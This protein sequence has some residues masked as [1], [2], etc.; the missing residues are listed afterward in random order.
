MDKKWKLLYCW[1]WKKN[2]ECEER[3]L[4]IV[5]VV[6]DYGVST[7]VNTTI[8][9]IYILIY[10]MFIFCLLKKSLKIPGDDDVSPISLK[11]ISQS[12]R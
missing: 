6:I 12:V 5:V 8:L 9:L 10:I 2:K 1:E 11:P 3:V 7:R 4:L